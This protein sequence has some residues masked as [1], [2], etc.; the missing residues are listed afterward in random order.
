[1]EYSFGNSYFIQILQ[2]PNT[3]KSDVVARINYQCQGQRAHYDIRTCI[4]KHIAWVLN[5]EEDRC[6]IIKS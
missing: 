5:E 3:N 6:H 4:G 1:M 2:I